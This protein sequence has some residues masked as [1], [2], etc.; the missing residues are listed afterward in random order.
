M[1]GYDGYSM[2]NNAVAAYIEGAVPLSGITAA[3]VRENEIPC[4]AAVLKTLI[5]EGAVWTN[6]YHHT[7]KHFNSTDFYRPDSVKKQVE[8][9]GADRIAEIVAAAKARRKAASRVTVHEDCRVEWLE[10]MGTRKRPYPEERSVDGCTVSVKGNTAT[11]TLPNG[12][13]F[14]K[15]LTTTGFSFHPVKDEVS[16]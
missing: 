12:A 11:I 8:V 6:E 5:A 15:R 4:S 14:T 9:L 16:A 2:S 10:W 3:W 7:S 1:S 13:V